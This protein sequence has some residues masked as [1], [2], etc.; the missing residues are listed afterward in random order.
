MLDRFLHLAA[1]AVGGF[2]DG[3]RAARRSAPG[4]V[5]DAVFDEI[6]RRQ[7]RV[8]DGLRRGNAAIAANPDAEWRELFELAAMTAI[9]SRDVAGDPLGALAALRQACAIL[10]RA[11]QEMLAA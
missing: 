5:D 9:D 3:V 4:P 8:I 11:E 6:V 7:P 10:D 2:V 1:G